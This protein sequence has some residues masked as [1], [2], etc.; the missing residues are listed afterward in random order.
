[1]AELETRDPKLK[2][3]LGDCDTSLHLVPKG[4]VTLG[5]L[6]E[7]RTHSTLPLTSAANQVW[8]QMALLLGTGHRAEDRLFMPVSLF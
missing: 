8:V 5:I 7:H 2:G 6:S 4:S 3:G 1:M